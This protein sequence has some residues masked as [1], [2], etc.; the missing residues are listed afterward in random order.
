[1]APDY[2]MIV[3]Q[4]TF[5]PT[6]LG[7]GIHAVSVVVQ[8]G[9]ALFLISMGA[10]NLF[11]PGADLAFLRRLGATHIGE[12]DTRL[13]GGLKLLSG[14]LLLAPGLLG[15]PVVF[16]FLGCLAAIGLFWIRERAL[17]EAAR[18][19]GRGMR[20][21][22]MGMALLAAAFMIW[23]REDSIALTLELAR[24]AATQRMAEMD[25]QLARDRDAPKVGDLAPDFEL[26]DPSGVER[27][28]LSSFRKKRPVALVF[29]SYT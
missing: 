29:G 15:M 1:M 23:E 11:R 2:Q 16:S 17:S 10:H 5:V 21:L 4:A 22:A 25:W 8:A 19:T 20:R 24:E 3:D 13:D 28:R 26:M 18:A 14:L 12:V 6:F 27:V 7:Y 9:L